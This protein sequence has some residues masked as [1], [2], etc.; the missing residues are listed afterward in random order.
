MTIA[1]I[2][3][4]VRMLHEALGAVLDKQIFF[5]VG[6]QKSGTTWVQHLLDGHP[7]ICCKGEAYF[8][9]VLLPAL[10][11]A[12]DFYSGR[13]KLEEL[14]RFDSEALVQ[15]FT[16]AVAL[17]F[18]R[19]ADS[20]PVR[21]IGEK[22]PEHA[23]C[24]GPLN[25]AFPDAKII[26]VIRD[27]RDVTVSGWFHN[28][29]QKKETFQ[30]RFP[31]MAAYAEYLLQNH[32]IPYIQQAR[33]FGRTFP[34]RYL[35]LRYEDLSAD[36]SAGVARML[37]FLGVDTSDASVRACCEAGSFR[38][39]AGGRENGVEDKSSFFRKGVVGDW[40]EHF[41]EKV[42]Q[43]FARIGGPLMQ[44]LGYDL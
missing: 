14:G 6:C 39:L 20:Q 43:V 23:M 5:V 34:D 15:V 8:G 37:D 10:Q 24:L 38:R 41:D 33:L 40:R 25:A 30:Q 29:R 3:S 21:C 31:T 11:Q 12:L 26:H 18:H 42:L 35:E 1:A 19:W 28:L 13:Q 17:Q 7:E 16:A 4:P 9:P 44:E 2:Q 27:G 22:T 32:W 36:C